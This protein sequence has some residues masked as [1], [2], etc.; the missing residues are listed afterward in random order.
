M[1][2]MCAGLPR[3]I[4][5]TSLKEG[6]LVWRPATTAERAMSRQPSEQSSLDTVGSWDDCLDSGSDSESNAHDAGV[7]KP[8]GP[9]LNVPV[10]PVPSLQTFLVL[11]IK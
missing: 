2:E 1:L 9:V 3:N 8:P 7:P 6:L 11:K 10:C 5:R 4:K